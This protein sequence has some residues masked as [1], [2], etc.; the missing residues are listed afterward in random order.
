MK[1]KKTKNT[2]I[3]LKSKTNKFVEPFPSI[4]SSLPVAYN[5]LDFIL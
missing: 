2:Y 5:Q 4:H 1:R 3:P